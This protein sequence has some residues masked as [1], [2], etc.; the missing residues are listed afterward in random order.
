MA[1]ARFNS[2]VMTNRDVNDALSQPVQAALSSGILFLLY[3]YD[4]R[5]FVLSHLIT[6]V[7]RRHFLI[8]YWRRAQLEHYY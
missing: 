4:S 6:Y 2:Q 7:V 5:K 3:R 8:Q 1:S